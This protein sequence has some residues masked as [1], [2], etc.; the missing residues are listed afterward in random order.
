MV[1]ATA[2]PFATTISPTPIVAVVATISLPVS[3]AVIAPFVPPLMA[4]IPPGVTLLHPHKVHRIAA[5]TVLRAVAGPVTRVLVRN[6]EV[7]HWRAIN[8]LTNQDGL[9]VDYRWRSTIA[10]SHLAIHARHKLSPYRDIHIGLRVCH[11]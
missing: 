10:K 11:A 2:T 5:S 4:A 3:T 8:R 7:H 1:L 6:M 9:Y